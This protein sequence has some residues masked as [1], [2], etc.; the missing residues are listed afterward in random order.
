AS[1][2]KTARIHAGFGLKFESGPGT[3][4]L[5]NPFVGTHEPARP[6]RHVKR[7]SCAGF[8]FDPEHHLLE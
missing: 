6:R 8:D 4:S 2:Q 1:A 7:T 3:T 5:N